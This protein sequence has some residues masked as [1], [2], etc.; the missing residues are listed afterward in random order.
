VIG[1]SEVLRQELMD[2]RDIHVC[3]GR[4]GPGRTTLLL[5]PFRVTSP[6]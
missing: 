2:E 6:L 3:G 5:G 1:F 4:R